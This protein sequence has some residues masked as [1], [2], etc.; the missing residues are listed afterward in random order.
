MT[1]GPGFRV[2][3]LHDVDATEIGVLQDL[4]D[5]LASEHG[6][7][8]PTEAEE[9]LSG[10][11]QPPRR[12]VPFLLTFDDGFVS[13]FQIAQSVLEPRG[14]R[15]VFFVC[16]GLI[17]LPAADQS[18]MV[19]RQVFPG[20]AGIRSETMPRLIA[21]SELRAMTAGGH[22]IGSHSMM[23]HRLS[24]LTSV[25]LEEDIKLSSARIAE[26]LGIRP[27]WF[28]YPFGNLESISGDVFR[29]VAKYFSFCCT[30]V[31]GVNGTGTHPAAVL[32]ES[33]DLG[34]TLEYV[35][36]TVDGGLD[37]LYG[38]QRRQIVR[39]VEGIHRTQ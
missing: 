18:R 23:H 27:Q 29:A 31:R 1:P 39:M 5:Y 11:L 10:R 14:L 24:S 34:A 13:N 32:R 22:T 33:V 15:G 26:E 37:V 8:T 17:D 4:L 21:W 30:G 25:E 35:K 28:A 19:S 36:L 20:N 3:I 16:P 7:I 38:L 6:F 2:L 9:I 12:P